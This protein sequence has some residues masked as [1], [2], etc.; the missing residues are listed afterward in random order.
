MGSYSEPKR[1]Y[2][3]NFHHAGADPSDKSL[4]GL[5]TVAARDALTA[6]YVALNTLADELC[7]D[8]DDLIIDEIT[9]V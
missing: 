6:G 3:V 2:E 5:T 9:L 8:L 1:D 4:Q 7:V